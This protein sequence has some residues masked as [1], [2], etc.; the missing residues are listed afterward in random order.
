MSSFPFATEY[1]AADV[2]L[3]LLLNA[4]T[5]SP[6]VKS[7]NGTNNGDGLWGIYWQSV[8]TEYDAPSSESYEDAVNYRGYN[9]E[10]RISVGTE[11]N[12]MVNVGQIEY[13]TDWYVSNPNLE[14]VSYDTSGLMEDTWN[15]D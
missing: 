12:P 6:G 3:S 10:F 13:Q 1:A 11:Y 9:Q 2:A 15:F 8:P 5:D 7:W 4:L 14:Q